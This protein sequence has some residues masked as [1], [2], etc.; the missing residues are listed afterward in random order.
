MERVVGPL[1][2]ATTIEGLMEQREYTIVLDRNTLGPVECSRSLSGFPLT[3]NIM[4]VLSTC[5]DVRDKMLERLPLI[6]LEMATPH[7]IPLEV[8]TELPARMTSGDVMM[9]CLAIMA[10]A[11]QVKKRWDYVD[12]LKY[13][14]DLETEDRISY[15]LTM[16]GSFAGLAMTSVGLPLIGQKMDAVELDE[17]G[18]ADGPAWDHTLVDFTSMFA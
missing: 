10:A 3:A 11:C 1:S 7:F 6:Q 5:R 2:D 18:P 9:F 17:R 16:V 15:T 14:S 8:C 13:L 12:Q 4:R